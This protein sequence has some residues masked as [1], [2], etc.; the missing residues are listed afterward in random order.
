MLR[1]Y[2]SESRSWRSQIQLHSHKQGFLL[3][4]ASTFPFA[5]W[6]T[7]TALKRKTFISQLC[8]QIKCTCM[9]TRSPRPL[10]NAPKCSKYLLPL[11]C[12]TVILFPY[13][14]GALFMS[15]LIQLAVKELFIVLNCFCQ[16]KLSYIHNGFHHDIFMY[17]YDVV[18]S[19]S[20]SLPPCSLP[21]PTDHWPP[22]KQTPALVT[23]RCCGKTPW[24]RELTEQS[25]YLDFIVPGRVHHGGRGMGAVVGMA[26]GAGSCDH[27]STTNRKQHTGSGE[28]PM[29]SLKLP[30]SVTCVLWGSTT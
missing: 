10:R 13:E 2:D 20:P 28:K 30:P 21:T 15:M 19:H 9:E 16:H 14:A 1:N 29:I 4:C 6:S 26:I 27:L 8:F 18:W 23:F 5:V 22:P 17:V 25:V 11:F 3:L 7:H 12:L 24:P